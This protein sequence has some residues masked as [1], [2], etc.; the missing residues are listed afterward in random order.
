MATTLTQ[1]AEPQKL[2]SLDGLDQPESALYH[3]QQQAIYVTSINGSPVEANG[4]GYI[5]KLSADGKVLVKQWI[6]GLD[7]P[8]GM[9]ISDGTL[10][11]A[12]LQA[13]Y[14]IDLKQQKLLPPVTA[15]DAKMLN[16]VAIDE[17]GNVYVTD[18]LGGAIYRYKDS[19]LERWFAHADLPH[20]NGIYYQNGRLLIAGWGREMQDDFTTTTPGSI[21]QLDLADPSSSFKKT[22]QQLGNLDGVTQINDRVLVNDWVNGNVFSLTDDGYELLFNAGKG[23]A[24]ISSHKGVLFVPMMLDNRL[25]AYQVNVKPAAE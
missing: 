11:V 8:K 17:Q 15:S 2:W 21:Y 13:L 7:S 18:L 9:A 1:A 16:D 6:G 10:Y 23:A 20:P 24:D 5:S 3:P 25:D 12:G 4:K 22:A 14:I 19:K